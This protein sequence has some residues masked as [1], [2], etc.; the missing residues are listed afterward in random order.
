MAHFAKFDPR[1]F[2]ENEKRAGGGAGVGQTTEDAAPAA[3]ETLATLATLAASIPQNEKRDVVQSSAVDHP[4]R[5]KARKSGLTPAKAAK[6]AKVEPSDVAEEAPWGEVEEERSAIIEYDGG[7]P[8]VWAVALARLDPACPPC[9]VSLSRW[10]QFLDDCGLFL[11]EGWAARA[12]ALGWGPLDLFGCNRDKP[13]ARISQ[14][15][16]VW[17]LEGRKLL[18]LTA[19]T[20]AIATHS[21][22]KL[23]LCR[24]QLETGGVLAWELS[25]AV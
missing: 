20:A 17:L 10:Q 16:L 21:G 18:A 4:D 3:S 9:D 11:D 2:L 6:V 14:A 5:P 25:A 13:F 24:Q 12:E 23:T 8:R 1:A 7:A 22:G 15:G 19:D